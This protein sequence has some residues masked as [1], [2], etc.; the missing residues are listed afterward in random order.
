MMMAY[1]IWRCSFITVPINIKVNFRCVSQGTIAAVHFILTNA[2]KYDVDELSLGQEIQQLGLPKDNAEIISRLFREN[3]ESLTSQFS[4]E[5]YRISRYL[6]ASWR[7][8]QI[9]AS[10][11][12]TVES[13]TPLIHMKFIVDTKPHEGDR[14]VEKFST[15]SDRI[16]EIACGLSKE[17]LYVLIHELVQAQTLLESIEN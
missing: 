4:A 8:D 17:K 6:G 14:E 10:N 9:I 16:Q 7:V 3:K 13:M 1:L 15:D 11:D 5:S 12:E 2:T